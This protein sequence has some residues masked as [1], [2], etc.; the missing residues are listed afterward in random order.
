MTLLSQYLHIH[1]QFILLLFISSNFK[2]YLF[3]SANEI[4]L[5]LKIEGKLFTFCFAPCATVFVP[6]CTQMVISLEVH[7][8]LSC[9][10]FERV[11]LLFESFLLCCWLFSSTPSFYFV[12]RAAAL[13]WN[14]HLIDPHPLFSRFL[15]LMS[16]PLTSE[17]CSYI[18]PRFSHLKQV[19]WVTG[20]IVI[21][22][23]ILR[24]R[25]F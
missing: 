6:H 21:S 22:F 25:L 10:L 5:F 9:H 1:F 17:S 23:H 15:S 20:C 18:I 16:V 14:I 11:A 7:C 12:Q 2:I 4:N 13:L 3:L 24:F 8:R 19:I